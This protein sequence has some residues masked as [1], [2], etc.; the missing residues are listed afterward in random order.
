MNEHYKKLR[1]DKI[2]RWGLTIALVLLIIH[3]VLL[4]VTIMWLPPIAPLYNQLPWGE[5]RLASRWELFIPVGI[6]YVFFIGNYF[7]IIKIYEVMPL[8]A[9]IVSISTLL[10]SILGIVFIIRTIQILL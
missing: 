4:A 2:I 3:L 1:Q 5:M 7:I 9:R 10:V 8:V 6:S